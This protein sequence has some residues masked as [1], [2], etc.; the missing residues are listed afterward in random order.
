MSYSFPRWSDP[1]L[2]MPRGRL[3]TISLLAMVGWVFTAC[4]GS[5]SGTLTVTSSLPS[6]NP[7]V[8]GDGTLLIDSARV[9]VSAIEFED[10]GL[11]DRESELG[12]A[13]ID[14]DVDGSKTVVV[15]QDVDTGSYNVLGLE[16]AVGGAGAEFADFSGAEPASLLVTGSYSGS[17]FTF[18]SV[19]VPEVEFALDP[20][21]EVTA[22]GNASVSITID[23]AAWF[24]AADGSVLDPTDPG[25][26]STID[27]NILAAL[28]ASAVDFER[29]STLDN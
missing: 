26:R 3:R 24:T 27:E 9:A 23:V 17:P 5:E 25:S 7:L 6:T 20:V 19:V 4:G 1:V 29:D 10:E 11:I 12:A 2:A 28:E 13:V 22:G 18:R 14:I 8:L 15:A 16:F 21:V